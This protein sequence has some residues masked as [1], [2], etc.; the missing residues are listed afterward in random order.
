MPGLAVRAARA[1]ASAPLHL[2]PHTHRNSHRD[3]ISQ[4]V[5]PDWLPQTIFLLHGCSYLSVETRVA[6]KGWVQACAPASSHWPLPTD[7]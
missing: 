1:Y 3:M 4:R 2:L 6:M 5:L 7:H